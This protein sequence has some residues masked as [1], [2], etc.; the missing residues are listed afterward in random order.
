MIKLCL[1]FLLPFITHAI[2]YCLTSSTFPNCLKKADVL[3]VAKI[4]NPS[5]FKDLR[6]ISLLPIFSKIIEKVV[7]DQLR[8]HLATY[9]IIPEIQSGFQHGFSCNTALLKIT[10]D[11]FSA[12]DA[13][14]ATLLVLLDFSRA[15]DTLNHEILI[16]IL[17]Y[18]GLSANSVKFFQS[19]L[20][21]RYQRVIY[22][23]EMSQTRKNDTGVPQGSI[24]G[25][26]LFILY[27]LNLPNRCKSSSIHLYADDTQI[28]NSFYPTNITQACEEIC[29]DLE[30][31]LNTSK[32]HHLLL[33]PNKSKVILFCRKNDREYLRGNVNLRVGNTQLQ[34]VNEVKNLGLLIDDN[35][36]FTSHV[37][38]CI[39]NAYNVLRILYQ[40]R[41]CF[42][43]KL[44]RTLC[45][46]LVLSKLNYCDIVYGPCIDSV[47]TLKVQ[48]LQNSCLRFIYGI[49]KFDHISHK[50]IE[51]KWLDMNHRRILHSLCLYQKIILFKS[52][53]YLYAKIRFRSDV[54]SLNLRFKGLITPPKHHNEFFKRSFIYTLFYYYNRLPAPYKMLN[55]STFRRKVYQDLLAKN[56]QF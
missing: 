20:M 27:T 10:D 12:L 35:L 24:L 25:P 9:K 55:L 30:N 21:N 8:P 6:P 14:K 4:R 33:N 23:E 36:R 48:R 13:G 31:L 1:P 49:R 18:C 54:H 44:K 43:R 5:H 32:D 38:H 17:T 46:S 3:P 37:N 41:D 22:R 50:L 26:L 2:N 16:S 7:A 34:I 47:V 45:D 19:Y 28:Y 11:I 42:N 39:A 15:F 53:P 40:N 52:P 51:A 29:K 56:L